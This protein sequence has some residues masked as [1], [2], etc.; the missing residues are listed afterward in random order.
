MEMP[1]EKYQKYLGRAR[2]ERL[3]RDLMRQMTALAALAF[4]SGITKA[5][6]GGDNQQPA[7]NIHINDQNHAEDDSGQGSND[8]E[9]FKAASGAHLKKQKTLRKSITVKNA[10]NPNMLKPI[11]EDVPIE[12]V[13]KRKAEEAKKRAAEN[14]KKAPQKDDTN[15]LERDYDIL[16]KPKS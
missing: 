13:L 12:V 1:E 2:S 6:T 14:A 4:M 15:T 9:D 11:E 7:D 16:M 8:D 5:A 3:N 10:L